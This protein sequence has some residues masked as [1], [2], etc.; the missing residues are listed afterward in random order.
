M[1]SETPPP[2]GI[3]GSI[4]DQIRGEIRRSE[5]GSITFHRFMQLC[6]Y[7]P[8]YGYYN[9][10]KTR[11]GKAGD[12][13][14][15]AHCAPVFARLLARHLERSWDQ[16]GRPSGFDLIEL[17][18]G[19]GL[20]ATEL[21]SFLHGR[22]PECFAALRYIGVEQS[23]VLGARLSQALRPFAERSMIVADWQAVSDLA[24]QPGPGPGIVFANEFFDALPFHLMVWRNGGWMERNVCLNNWKLVWRDAVPSSPD[25][26]EQAELRFDPN[27]ALSEREDGC[28]AE[29]RPEANEW[30]R[31]IGEL[32]ARSASGGELLIVD[33][34]YTMEELRR[35]R[36]P[37]GSALAYHRHRAMDDLLADPGDQDITAH[38][39]FTELM[40][41]AAAS[42]LRRTRFV[43]QAEFLMELGEQDQ[44]SDL[45]ADCPSE[46]ERLRRT[47]LL[48]TL[49]L[50]QGMGEAFRVL[51]MRAGDHP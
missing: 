11:L 20:F 27:L 12:F 22:L 34:G 44:F 13:Y 8:Q 43:S 50:P 26:A 28:I 25:L 29:V 48:K 24:T 21:L 14:T 19:D 37:Q 49:I 15:S 32:L 5:S 41:A 31:R 9:S 30:L 40:Q 36:F 3:A 1:A 7:H 17:G 18:P 42:G 45:F 2:S 39:N 4:E 47:Q 33:Y 10:Q 6:L 16:F 23:P 51:E 35:G 38:V 46:S